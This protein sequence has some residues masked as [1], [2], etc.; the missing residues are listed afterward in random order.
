MHR[1]ASS[2]YLVGTA[3]IIT[4]DILLPVKVTLRKFNADATVDRRSF[5]GFSTALE[6]TVIDGQLPPII[7]PRPQYTVNREKKLIITFLL[8]LLCHIS[9]SIGDI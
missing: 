2:K 3:T 1:T 6:Y 7:A 9:V 8:L 5:F 4:A